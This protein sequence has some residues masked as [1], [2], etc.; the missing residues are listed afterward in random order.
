MPAPY[1]SFYT[2]PSQI[3]NDFITLS[4]KEAHHIINVLR[5]KSGEIITIID[6]LGHIYKCEITN[7]QNNILKAQIISTL[8]ENNES[9]TELT[10]AIAI[11]KKGKFELII[12]KCTELGVKKFIPLLSERTQVKAKSINHNRCKKI[13]ISAMKQSL[14]SFL[15]EVEQPI[16][17]NKLMQRNNFDLKIIAHEKID[18]NTIHKTLSNAK[19]ARKVILAIGPEGG[20]S[21]EE[22]LVFKQSGYT[23]VSLGKRRLRTE[24]AA[25]IASAIILDTLE[26]NQ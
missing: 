1:D 8:E 7:T 23:L 11:P 15:P 6:G 10:L 17:L 19:T 4:D 20:F 3:Q 5:K 14:R 22:I 18:D 26:T 24:T 21:E 16:H 2:P 25:I 9:N 12:E 13:A